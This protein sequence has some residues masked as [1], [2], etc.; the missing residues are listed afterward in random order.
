MSPEGIY[1]RD[2]KPQAVNTAEAVRKSRSKSVDS[3]A[4]AEDVRSLARLEQNQ[5]GRRAGGCVV[6]RN[7]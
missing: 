1:A 5:K 7:N 3:V 6:E 2:G 4:P